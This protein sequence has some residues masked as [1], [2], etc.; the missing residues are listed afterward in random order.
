MENFLKTDYDFENHQTKRSL[1]L[2]WV[3]LNIISNI[4]FTTDKKYQD[5]FILASLLHD[6]GQIG[7][8]N[9]SHSKEDQDNC[10]HPRDT[11]NLITL[12][13]NLPGE[14]EKIILQHHEESDGSGFP[15]HLK[16]NMINPLAQ[17]FIVARRFCESICN[18]Y[19]DSI[20]Y[21]IV[22]ESL[23][24]CYHQGYFK[25]AK[26]ALKKTLKGMN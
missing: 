12:I 10:P 19:Q 16:H 15:M 23:D 20:D 3:T 17:I 14:V 5:I 9:N 11:I 8:E 2:A 6:I 26:E 22:L 13:D 7:L 4:P 18:L 24:R 21:N 25:S 1:Y